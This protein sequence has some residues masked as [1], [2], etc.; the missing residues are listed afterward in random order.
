M[1]NAVLAVSVPLV[2]VRLSTC[3][4]RQ[5]VTG[6][7]LISRGRIKLGKGLTRDINIIIQYLHVASCLD[8]RASSR[9]EIGNRSP[10]HNGRH[11]LFTR[12]IAASEFIRRL[13]PTPT[14]IKSP[15]QGTPTNRRHL[16][17]TITP[18]P[19]TKKHPLLFNH[20]DQRLGKCPSS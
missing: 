10:S 4:W 18:L 13:R 9:S 17:T 1:D 2:L 14:E 20:P 5:H 15:S 6:G 19:T 16:I 3:T 8:L 11:P 7:P 12:D